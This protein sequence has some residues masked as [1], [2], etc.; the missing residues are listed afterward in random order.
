VNYLTKDDFFKIRDQVENEI[1]AIENKYNITINIINGEWTINCGDFQG[2]MFTG[3]DEGILNDINNSS[4][5]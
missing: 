2:K 4:I 5:M 3:Y 1:M